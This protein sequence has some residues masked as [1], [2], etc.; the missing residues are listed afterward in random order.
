M[1][2]PRVGI[3]EIK[4]VGLTMFDTKCMYDMNL[5][6]HN[7]PPLFLSKGLRFDLIKVVLGDFVRQKERGTTCSW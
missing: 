5:I 6:M 4:Y 1:H 7:N 2:Y 3:Q